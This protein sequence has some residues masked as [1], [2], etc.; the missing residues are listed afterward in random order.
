MSIEKDTH[1]KQIA[2]W[3]KTSHLTR[4]Q[5]THNYH[6]LITNFGIIELGTNSFLYREIAE[7]QHLKQ[8]FNSSFQNIW[9]AYVNF[10]MKFNK[11]P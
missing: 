5:T 9:C 8:K 6:T 3:F 4:D 11:P 1:T 7:N 2:T 10:K